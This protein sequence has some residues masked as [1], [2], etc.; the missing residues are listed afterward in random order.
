MDHDQDVAY[1]YCRCCSFVS[2]DGTG[3]PER[4]K[5][6]GIHPSVHS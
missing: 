3:W 4:T 2:Y 5:S 6:G 1:A